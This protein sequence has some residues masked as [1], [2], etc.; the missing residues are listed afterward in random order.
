MGAMVV[1]LIIESIFK[2]YLFYAFRG[3]DNIFESVNSFM[4]FLP[5]EAMSNL[6][7]EPFSNLNAVRSAANTMGETFTKSYAV[8][9][10]NIAIVAVWTFIFIYLSYALLKKRDL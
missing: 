1:W 10:S 9:F 6:I 3:V 8:E 4:R 2:A 5:F 7:K